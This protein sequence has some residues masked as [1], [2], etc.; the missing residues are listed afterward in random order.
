MTGIEIPL[1]SEKKLHYRLFEILPG[2]L[3][4]T[5]LTAPFW[6]SL[7]APTITALIIIAFFLLWLVRAI[8]LNIRVLQGYR[9][10]QTQIKLDWAKMLDDITD[11]KDTYNREFPKW[12]NDI[13]KRLIEKEPMIAPD[14]IIHAV[15]I[16]AYNEGVEVLEPTIKAVLASDFDSKKMILVMAYEGRDGAQS[17]TAVQAMIKKYANKFMEALAYEHPLTE[18]EVRGKGGNITYAGRQLQKYL[19]SKQIDPL[20]VMVTTLDSDNRPHKSYFS[21]LSYVV[22]AT[23]DPVRVSYQ[24]IPMFTNNIWDVPAPMRVIATGNSFWNIVLSLRPHVLRNFASHAQSMKA[25]IDTD[26]WSTRT[27]V[28]DGHQYWR[29]YFKFEG[30]YEVYPLYIPIYQDA[31][32]SS[33]YRKTLKAQFIQLRRWA[34][35]ASDV[36]YVADKAFFSKNKISKTDKIFKFLRLLEGHVSWAT[37]P[38]I[39]AFAAFVPLLLNPD[40]YTANQLP[41]IASRIQTVALVGIFVTFFLSIKT[42]PPKPKRYKSHKSIFMVLQWVLLPV[43]TIMF[44]AMAALVS[45]TR[46]M[47]GRYLDNFDVTDKVVKK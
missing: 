12:H 21:A 33:N 46:L 11:P 32:L 34:W 44:N 16:A 14:E 8:G 5:I 31:V 17:K 20:K 30:K 25:L 10:M 41:L 3:T 15:F 9:M 28:E 22:A 6:L 37:A 13:K 2:A 26:F 23:P 43:T 24:P 27:I 7:I 19:K 29:S 40:N 18:G 42:L 4:W 38:I 45:Q 35:G 39:L 1:Q 36:A 47:L